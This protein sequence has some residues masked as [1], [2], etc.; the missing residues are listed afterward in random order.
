M[1]TPSL[2]QAK[3]FLARVLPWPQDEKSAFAN[4]HWTFVPQD[5]EPGRKPPWTGRAVR[6]SMDAAKAVAWAMKLPDTRDFYVCLSMQSVA[7]E[8]TSQKG[9]KYHR[10]VRLAEN[11]VALKALW[12]DLDVK[13]ADLNSYTTPKEAVT[14]L[15]N[16]IKASGMPKPSMVVSSGGGF[17]VYW[18]VNRALTPAEWYPLASSLREAASQHGLKF[19]EEVT[20]D[21]ARVLRIPSTLNHKTTPPRPVKILTRT[22]FDYLPEKLEK[23]L[24]PLSLIHI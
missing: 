14:A 18:F 13:G 20:T 3:E 9:F 5:L 12:L 10:P 15:G 24:A 7:Q 2:D 17:H 16:F 8:V 1:T 21:A 6:N 19:D 4:I 22:D 23:I 11:A